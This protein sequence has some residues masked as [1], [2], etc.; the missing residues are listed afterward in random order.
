MRFRHV[1]NLNLTQLTAETTE[2]G[3]F[4]TTPGGKKYPSV[5]T[6]LGAG[7]DKSWLDK[8]KARVGEEEAAKILAQAGRR[9]TAVHD[10]AEKYLLNDPHYKKGHMPVNVAS[11]NNLKPFLD[12]NIGLVAGLELP[13]YSDFLR[14]AG[15]SDC[16]AKWCGIWSIVDFKTSRKV[17]TEEDI[18]HYFAQESAYAYMFFE[19][20]GLPVPQIVTLMTVDGS[21]PLVSV[22]RTKDYLPY[23]ME[24]R[25]KVA[26]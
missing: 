4:Y 11:F 8:W 3:R 12:E 9:G 10:L 1:P 25:N 14:V 5:T 26:F 13:L 20:T 18:I 19:R 21:E 17:K 22:K 7:S 23:F 24:I 15:R 2:N 16:I 6:V